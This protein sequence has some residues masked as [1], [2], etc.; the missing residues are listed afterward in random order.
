MQH[1]CES[2]VLVEGNAPGAELSPTVMRTIYISI[3]QMSATI[4][5]VGVLCC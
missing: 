5:M 3:A 1:I 2:Q 4:V